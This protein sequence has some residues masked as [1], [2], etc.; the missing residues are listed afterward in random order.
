[1]V[2]M[3]VTIGLIGILLLALAPLFMAL[4]RTGAVTQAR[5]QANQVT[6]LGM[7]DLQRFTY[8]QLGVCAAPSA[9]APSGLSDVVVLSCASQVATYGESPCS[10][11][12][13]NLPPAASY[14][15]AD[16]GIT[17]T[18]IRWVS[19]ADTGHI[20]KRLAVYVSWTDPVGAHV[21]SQQSSVR[22]P[23]PD[24]VVGLSPPSLS[25]PQ[26][27]GSNP[28]I[29]GGAWTLQFSVTTSGLT[30]SDK[31]YVAFSSL[32]G[33]GSPTDQ[34]VFLSSGDGT[35]W[36][37]SISSSSGYTFG[38]GSQY[39]VFSAIRS[40]DGKSNSVVDTTAQEFCTSSDP[41][42]S[43]STLPSILSST[44]PSTVSIASSGAL[45]ASVP[46]SVTVKNVTSTDAISVAFQTQNGLVSLYLSPNSSCTTSSCTFSGSIPS[47]AGYAFSATTQNFYF[48]ATQ[49]ESG[50]STSVDQGSTVA[51]A[52]SP[53]TFTAS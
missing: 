42:C 30:T 51:A 53:V 3:V 43:L 40:T 38:E 31:V 15:C 49:D 10:P 36:T 26:V 28:A 39:F 9:T 18:V 45:T 12:V 4:L 32:D 35:N 11:V 19:W 5:D 24:S 37:G 41:S 23:D 22:A 14:T 21:V 1:M 27:T 13:G 34:S 50:V 25:S 16:A 2:E 7:E 8:S 20:V 52:S 17:Y 47:S 29:I 48:T 6:T 44:V 33:S 46:V